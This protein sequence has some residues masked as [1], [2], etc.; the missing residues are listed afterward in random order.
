M[1]RSSLLF[2]TLFLE[3]SHSWYD[4][5]I[6][7]FPSI[8]SRPAA[9]L[10]HTGRLLYIE[11]TEMW[12]PSII[13][14]YFH[15]QEGP[16]SLRWHDGYPSLIPAFFVVHLSLVYAW[17]HPTSDLFISSKYDTPCCGNQVR[18]TYTLLQSRKILAPLNYF[19]LTHPSLKI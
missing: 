14:W 2:I 17:R 13:H 16:C 19:V 7:E 5:S 18:N 9:V 11:L 12:R 10:S 1:Y 6:S 8:S 3:H 15:G 4:I